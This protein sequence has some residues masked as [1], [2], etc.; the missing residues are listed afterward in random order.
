MID[1]ISLYHSQRS[2]CTEKYFFSM[3]F[4]PVQAV[5][6]HTVPRHHPASWVKSI[7]VDTHGR[8]A[9]LCDMCWSLS[10]VRARLAHESLCF[11][12]LIAACTCESRKSWGI[13]RAV[14]TTN[15][16]GL[17][18]YSRSYRTFRGTMEVWAFDLRRSSKTELITLSLEQHTSGSA[19][20]PRFHGK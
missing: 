11:Q 4:L 7:T 12:L 16:A 2:M 13:Q 1:C 14:L 5:L 15:H 6:S 17:C 18:R 20:F 9:T 3:L 8:C 10:H 19:H